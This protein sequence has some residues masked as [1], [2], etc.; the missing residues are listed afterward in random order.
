[1]FTRRVRVRRLSIPVAP[2]LLCE[3]EG[4]STVRVTPANGLSCGFVMRRAANWQSYVAFQETHYSPGAVTEA[5][6]GN[7]EPGTFAITIEPIEKE[8]R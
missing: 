3:S 5:G 4:D 8:Q 1:M 6:E 2:T 7:E